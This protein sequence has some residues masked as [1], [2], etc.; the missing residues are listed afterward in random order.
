ME[1]MNF[2][3]L[4][5]KFDETVKKFS[6]GRRLTT[7]FLDSREPRCG[8][9]RVAR[10]IG[11]QMATPLACLLFFPSRRFWPMDAGRCEGSNEAALC[12][13][14]LCWPRSCGRCLVGWC[15]P[16]ACRRTGGAGVF[17]RRQ[18]PHG[19]SSG[20]R[21]G[22]GDREAADNRWSLSILVLHTWAMSMLINMLSRLS[23]F[24]NVPFTVL[25]L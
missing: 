23:L 1:R 22:S 19:F 7:P 20:R 12:W 8:H 24:L 5:T 4:L 9:Q 6:K 21:Q 3:S 13:L 11:A 10:G 14:L 17:P 25:S 2:N 15:L 16:T 18:E